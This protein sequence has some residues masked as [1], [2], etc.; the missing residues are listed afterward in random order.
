METTTLICSAK[1]SGFN[2]RFFCQFFV[3][4][5]LYYKDSGICNLHVFKVNRTSSNF[6]AKVTYIQD[7][8]I[9][10][11][12]TYLFAVRYLLSLFLFICKKLLCIEFLLFF[13]WIY[14]YLH[15]Y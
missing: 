2:I 9:N 1:Y 15:S 3:W 5:F 8:Y 12:L 4:Q 6:S 13:R 10:I 14:L 11:T 7:L